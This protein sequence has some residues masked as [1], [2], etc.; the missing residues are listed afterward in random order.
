MIGRQPGKT[1]RGQCIAIQLTATQNIFNRDAL[2]AS[3]TAGDVRRYAKQNTGA[4]KIDVAANVS[5]AFYD[6]LTTEQQI[7]TT[8][9]DIT[10]LER[11]LRDA[12]Y[13]YQAGIT[14]KTDYK[15]ATIALNNAKALLKTNEELLKAKIEYLKALMGYPVSAPL[16]IKY[17]TLQMENEIV[18]DTL[19]SSNYNT[20]IEYQLLQTQYK[21]QQA[22]L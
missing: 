6:V 5:K 9:E 17:D 1:G 15:R 14:D 19:Q 18:L 13:Q 11:S 8:S 16:D 2:L 22:N 7:K 4:S 20:R 3:R 12:T 21:L 10:R